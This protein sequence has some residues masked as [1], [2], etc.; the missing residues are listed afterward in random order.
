[1]S[2]NSINHTLQFTQVIFQK[3]FNYD[4]KKEEKITFQ[5]KKF[6]SRPDDKN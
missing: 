4:K 2:F 5:Q 1:M 6:K 3:K